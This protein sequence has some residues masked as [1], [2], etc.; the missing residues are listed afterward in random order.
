LFKIN[1]ENKKNCSNPIINSSTNSD[2]KNRISF[3][4]SDRSAHSGG[5]NPNI[6]SSSNLNGTI[7]S[8]L[9]THKIKSRIE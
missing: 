4:K 9:V 1:E 5:S 6:W 3:G 2:V 8:V 7:L